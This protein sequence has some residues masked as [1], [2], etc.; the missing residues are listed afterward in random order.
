MEGACGKFLFY[1]VRIN[2]LL[3]AYRNF[4]SG[5][6]T[7]DC[8]C[9]VKRQNTLSVGVCDQVAPLIQLLGAKVSDN[10]VP[11]LFSKISMIFTCPIFAWETGFF[12]SLLGAFFVSRLLI[13]CLSHLHLSWLTINHQMIR[14]YFHLIQ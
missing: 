9:V 1:Y 3:I 11:A 6:F 14:R 12:G 4:L 13:H 2:C 5:L 8:V 7:C 10:E